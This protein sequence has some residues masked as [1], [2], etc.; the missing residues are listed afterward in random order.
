[1]PWPPDYRALD[2]VE[3][4]TLRRYVLLLAALVSLLITAGAQASTP[5][6]RRSMAHARVDAA[7]ELASVMLPPGA[8]KVTGDPSVNRGLR[9]EGVACFKKWV[10]ED[11]RF[12]RVAGKPVTAWASMLEHPPK[13]TGSIGTSS[14]VDHG[15][16]IAWAIWFFLPAQ[17]DVVS[18]MLSIQFRFAS[19]GGTAIRVDAIAVGESGPNQTPCV[20]SY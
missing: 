1:M 18:R 10:V 9:P 14:Q 15:K 13:R 16:T 6:A 8:K 11:H 3:I 20:T 12:W 2:D 19:G 7:K 5:F 17:A 4:R